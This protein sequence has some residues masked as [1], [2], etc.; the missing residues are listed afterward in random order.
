LDGWE[1][2][3]VT[4]A[5][6]TTAVGP[7]TYDRSYPEFYRLVQTMKQVGV[8][9]GCGRAM[10]EYED[11]HNR[12]GSPMEPMLLPFFTDSCIGSM[13]GLYFEASATTPYHFIN[14][15]EL[16]KAGS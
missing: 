4:D 10:W 14:S 15:T 2:K 9:H 7:P 6:G 11:Q 8:D 3:P 16:S 13:E 12:Y 1:Q 5:N